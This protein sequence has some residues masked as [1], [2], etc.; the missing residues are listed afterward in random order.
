MMY[1]I[2]LDGDRMNSTTYDPYAFTGNLV[3]TYTVTREDKRR[4][5]TIRTTIEVIDVGRPDPIPPVD[6]DAMIDVDESEDDAPKPVAKRRPPRKG[7]VREH[8]CNHLQQHGAVTARELATE[9]EMTHQAVSM[10]LMRNEGHLY[11][12]VDVVKGGGDKPSVLW[13]LAEIHSAKE[14]V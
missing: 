4:N 12:R 9:L 10:H 14:Q 11:V 1:C 2:G 13:G 7:G 3:A 5:C 6:P 8:I